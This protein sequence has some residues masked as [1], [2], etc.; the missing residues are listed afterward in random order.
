LIFLAKPLQKWD[1]FLAHRTKIGQPKKNALFR[2]AAIQGN[3]STLQIL[4]TEIGKTLSD[5][6][7]L[8]R[9]KRSDT[10]PQLP[11]PAIEAILMS[12]RVY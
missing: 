10:P 6:N 5:F 3:L 2:K 4:E 7:P 9:K 12:H 11:D 8:L 1:L